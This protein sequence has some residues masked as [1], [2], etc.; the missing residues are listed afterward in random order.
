MPCGGSPCLP[1]PSS[2]L[3]RGGIYFSR[4]WKDLPCCGPRPGSEMGATMGQLTPCQN[5]QIGQFT[6]CGDDGPA[7]AWDFVGIQQVAAATER[8]RSRSRSRSRRPR[9]PVHPEVPQFPESVAMIRGDHRGFRCTGSR[10]PE[11]ERAAPRRCFPID[12]QKR[13][14]IDR[15]R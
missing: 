1:A 7:A 14:R 11:S 8:S 5:L 3:G 9:L 10:L 4:S 12:G 2:P 6:P 13:R 15:C